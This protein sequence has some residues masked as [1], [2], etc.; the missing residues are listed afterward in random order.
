MTERP[1][2]GKPSPSRMREIN[3]T[4]RYAMWSVFAVD[5]RLGVADRDPLAAEVAAL[6]TR[7]AD[8]GVVVRGT[9][10]LAG[11]RADADLMIWWHAEDP[12]ARL[13]PTSSTRRSATASG[14][15]L[16]SLSTRCSTARWSSTPN[17]R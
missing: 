14:P 8:D 3:D 10:D 17:P 5:T 11:M 9:Y 7:V 15:I 2:P 1:L 13:S 12:A 6:L 16:S 4:I